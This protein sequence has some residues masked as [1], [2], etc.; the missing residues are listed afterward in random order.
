MRLMISF[1]ARKD[2]NCGQIAEHIAARGDRIV[3][4]HDLHAHSCADCAYECMQSGC[5]Y[6]DDGV[7]ALYQSMA[8]FERVVLIVPMYGGN[9]CA[10]YFAFCERGQDFFRSEE[11]YETVIERLY[12]IGVYG[13]ASESPEFVPC[14][15]KWFSGTAYHGRVLGLERHVYGQ[16]MADKLLDVDDAVQKIEQFMQ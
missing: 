3:H 10:Q 14:L 1:S 7:H 13:S 5:R 6:R 16:R 9:P 11:A 8:D 15:E 2:G 4:Y 12:I